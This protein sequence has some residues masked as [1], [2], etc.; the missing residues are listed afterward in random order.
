MKA[1]ALVSIIMPAYNAEQWIEEGIASVLAQTHQ[2]WELLVVDDGCT[3]RTVEKV[4]GYQDERIQLLRQENKGVSAARNLALQKVKGEYMLFLDADDMLL[5]HSLESRLQLFSR[6]P[7]LAF[8]DG[9]VYVTGASVRDLERTWSPSFEGYPKEELLGLK[10]SCFVTITWLIRRDPGRDYSFDEELTHCEDLDF[11]ISI[12][13]QGKYGHVEEPIMYF[14]RTG[15]SAMNDL[16]GL[17]KG[18]R[19]L[20]RKW[21]EQVEGSKGDDMVKKAKRVLFRAYLKKGAPIKAL[22]SQKGW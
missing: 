17:E 7:D 6:D 13:D 10:D 19:R 8:V 18:Y 9:Q 1:E 5:P 22:K 21:K 2:R 4:Q 12:A 3:D 15:R 20:V 16:E 14:R 11:F